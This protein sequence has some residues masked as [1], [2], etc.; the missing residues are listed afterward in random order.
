MRIF[1]RQH[2]SSELVEGMSS[3]RSFLFHVPAGVGKTRLL[4]EL[5]PRFPHLIRISSCRTPEDL[6][7]H[8][9]RE[10]W[11]QRNHLLRDHFRSSEQL[12]DSTAASLKRL[13]LSALKGAENVLALEHL[14]FSSLPLFQEVQEFSMKAGAAVVYVSRSYHLEQAG[15]LVRHYPGPADRIEIA[16]FKP[17]QA[18]EF[19]KLA[20]DELC[21][22]AENRTE[23]LAKVSELSDG[24]PGAILAMVQMAGMPKY[25]I[26]DWIKSGS[27]YIDF[28]L[29]A[30][31]AL[32]SYD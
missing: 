29:A 6:F 4:E 28:R 32:S 3:S 12:E 31:A 27:L 16:P 14:G 22:Q 8:L 30:N 5:A 15:Y 24:N 25:R 13:C 19:A 1:G 23:F 2:E 9:A 21:L 7:R 20:A 11:A 10:L 26:G 17:H 18:E